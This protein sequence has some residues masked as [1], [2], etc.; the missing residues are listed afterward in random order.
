MHL[1]KKNQG[2]H[3][4]SHNSNPAERWWSLDWYCCIRYEEKEI[5]SSYILEVDTTGL[6]G[7]LNIIGQRN[8]DSKDLS[9]FWLEQD[10]VEW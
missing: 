10:G 3:L 1:K 9:G 7:G 6:A 5:D 8:K 4:R 2:N